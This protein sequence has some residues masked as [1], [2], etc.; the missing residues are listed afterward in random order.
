MT[1]R[2]KAPKMNEQGRTSQPSESNAHLAPAL[3]ETSV[4]LQTH[5]ETEERGGNG[6][7]PIPTWPEAAEKMQ[8]DSEFPLVLDPSHTI[9]A[10]S[11]G[12]LRSRLLGVHKS[13]A[14]QS[15]VITSAEAGDGKTLVATNLA[16]SLGQLAT[17]RILLVDGDL[18]LATASRVFKLQ[19]TS[20]IGEFLQGAPFESAVRTTE[21]P[22]LSVASAGLVPRKALPELFQR[23]SSR[24]AEFLEQAKR[25]FDLI[26]IDTIPISAHVVDWEILTAP[27]E[28]LLFVVRMRR[29]NRQALKRA[30]SRLD[31]KRLLGVIINN[32]D[33]IYDYDY[34]YYYAD[35]PSA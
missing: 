20:G 3:V 21:F 25:K 1:K 30:A 24:W 7:A 17:K 8:L 26:I 19:R 33:E 12:I 14:I 6:G 15:V 22:A 11:F 18:R 29:T 32:A 16:L 4:G 9:A 35:N 23:Q 5:R 2:R 28:A 10:E 13:L 34:G 31:Q 27:C